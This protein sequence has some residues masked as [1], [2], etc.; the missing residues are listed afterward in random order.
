MSPDDARPAA[1]HLT[2]MSDG[3]LVLRSRSGDAS[4]YGELWR[5]H[6]RSGIVAARS[7]TSSIDADDLVQ[8]AYARIFQAIKRGGG[9]T[10]GFRA[11]LFTSIRNTAAGWGRSH[12]ETAI[13]ELDSVEDPEASA[14]ATDEAL[15]RGLTNQAFRSLPTRWQEVLWYTE[16]EQMKPAEAAP[17][18]GMSA[19]AVAQLAVRAREGL[20]EAWIQAHLRSVEDGS[21]CQFTIE[22]LGTYARGNLGVRAKN[23]VEAHLA[24]CAR[25]AVVASEAKE[26]SR[27]LAL[28][29]LPI[30]VGVGGA[31]AY[32]ASLQSGGAAVVALA[33]MP[34]SVI[35]GAVVAG[36]TGTAAPAGAAASG[37]SAGASTSFATI[38]SVAAGI[39]IAGAVA[40]GFVLANQPHTAPAD[41]AQAAGPAAAAPEALDAAPADA[42][43][44]VVAP[45]VAPPSAPVAPVARRA[46]TPVSSVPVAAAPVATVPVA[47]APVVSAPVTTAPSAA[48]PAPS[49]TPPVTAPPFTTPPTTPPVTPPAVVAPSLIGAQITR[50]GGNEV[51]I[52]ATIRTAPGATVTAMVRGFVRGTAVAGADGVATIVITPKVSDVVQNASVSFLVPGAA[53][54]QIALGDLLGRA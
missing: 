17:L 44:A 38:G 46:T 22:K 9:P 31:T 37:T 50:G 23:R 52:T 48:P 4:A 24:E 29:L 20:R 25:C 14:H 47:S 26:V 27:R 32:L 16:I 39:A 28:V 8:E 13:D 43:P 34:S 15:D 6:Y 41:Q 2:E 21:E 19:N 12:K 30:V 40:L 53:T 1:A 5:R 35:P 54:L 42:A 36:G 45:V 3:D 10:G 11:Y 33:G 7:I 18:L 49:T 51:T